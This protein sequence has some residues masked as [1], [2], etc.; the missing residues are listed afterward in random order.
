MMTQTRELFIESTA[1]K[2][3]DYCPYGQARIQF[4]SGTQKLTDDDINPV[5]GEIINEICNI[6]IF[7]LISYTTHVARVTHIYSAYYMI[8][9]NILK[10]ECSGTYSQ[11]TRKHIGCFAKEINDLFNIDLTYY[12]FKSVYED[13]GAMYIDLN[14]YP[15]LLSKTKA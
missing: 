8:G 9:T 10:I 5:T 7:D 6:D 15:D 11:T 14:T 4:S 1:T 12:D 3:L 2:R 13:N